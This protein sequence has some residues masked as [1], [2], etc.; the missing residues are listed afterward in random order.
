LTAVLGLPTYL[1]RA[2]V[3]LLVVSVGATAGCV[4]DRPTL[5]S[6]PEPTDASPGETTTTTPAAPARVA[7]AKATSIDLFDDATTAAPSDQITAAEAT[8]A[9]DIPL[10][11]LVKGK[12]GARLE[13][14]LPNPPSGS[15][16]W[17]DADDV[18]VS[19]VSFRIEVSL[20]AHR[21]RVFDGH[22]KV[23]DEP[24][25]IGTAEIPAPGGIYFIKELLQPPEPDGPYGSY[26]YGLSGFSTELSSFDEGT[27][28]I[29]IH[30]TNDPDS[31]GSDADAGCIG[32]MNDVLDRLVD[33]IGLPLGTPV[34]ILR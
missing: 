26:A 28:V 2:S 20:R 22:D 31:I 34:E 4:G 17:V 15:T 6:E 5:A 13:V 8:A 9:P 29:G 25:S 23:L 14:Y 10:V 18:T 27:G 1:R 12:Q 30:G 19:S 16:A 11:F 33:D 24:A 7:Q 21:V 3:A 32:L